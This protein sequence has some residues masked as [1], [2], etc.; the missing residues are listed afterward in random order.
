MG[1]FDHL[2]ISNAEHLLRDNRLVIPRK[3]EHESEWELCHLQ[4]LLQVAVDIELYTIPFYMA[5]MYSIVDQA[6]EARRLL[7]SVVNQEMLHMQCAANVANAFCTDLCIRAP[8][9]GGNVPHLDFSLDQPNPTNIYTPFSTAIGPLDVQRI[10]AMCIIE[11]PNWS[12]CQKQEHESGDFG[13]IGELYNFIK[14]QAEFFAENIHG[15]RHQV[16]HFTALYPK[17]TD[18]PSLT[19]TRDGKEGLKEVLALIDLIVDQGEGEMEQAQYV[20]YEF[21]NH[22]DDLQPAWD[23]FEKFSYLREQPLPE[24]FAT[25]FGNDRSREI[26]EILLENFGE[27]LIVMNKLFRGE[28]APDFAVIMFKLGAGIAACWENGALPVFSKP[29]TSAGE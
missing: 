15:N 5:A 21:Q 23:H 27:F 29:D 2:D 18:A 13:S 10:N 11:Y 20:K 6:S 19:V 22:V 26:Q 1:L 25:G 7:R 4:E 3:I 16:G 14:K 28:E 12:A 9:Y 17:V 8:S 24:T